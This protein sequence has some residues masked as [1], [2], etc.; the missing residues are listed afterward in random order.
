MEV[1]SGGGQRIPGDP[2]GAAWAGI[3]YEE[4][5]IGTFP[6][7]DQRDKEG[8]RPGLAPVQ[9]GA[10]FQMVLQHQNQLFKRNSMFRMASERNCRAELGLQLLQQF[11]EGQGGKDWTVHLFS[12]VIQDV[13]LF[14]VG[15]MIQGLGHPPSLLVS[16]APKGN[17]QH[18]VLM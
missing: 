15:S 13:G 10:A 7:A 6:W 12:A 3:I 16:D 1:G 4:D 2:R 11:A 18:S 17:W 9:T 8:G 5:A 14:Q